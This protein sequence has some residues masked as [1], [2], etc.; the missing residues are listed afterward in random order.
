MWHVD[1]LRKTSSNLTLQVCHVLR[2]FC[3]S[4]CL[5]CMLQIR[6]ASAIHPLLIIPYLLTE[7]KKPNPWPS[8]F[9][10]Y[11]ELSS[12]QLRHPAG[13]YLSFHLPPMMCQRLRTSQ[14]P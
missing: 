2:Q 3:S 6:S 5:D 7:K 13:S 1:D 11:Q 9:L 10:S 14:D 8:Q 12:I 4:G